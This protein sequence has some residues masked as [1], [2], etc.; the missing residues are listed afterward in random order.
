V[1]E[2]QTAALNAL[3]ILSPKERAEVLHFF[4][5]VWHKLLLTS[6]VGVLSTAFLW[7]NANNFDS[8][9]FKS[10]GGI[11]GMFAAVTLGPEVKRLLGKEG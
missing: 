9:E 6:I 3:L 8:S 2:Q 11:V 1:T 5:T 10:I 4:T 7:L